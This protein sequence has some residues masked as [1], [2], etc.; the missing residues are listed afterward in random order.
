MNLFLLGAR[1]GFDGMMKEKVLE[2]QMNLICYF[3]VNVTHKLTRIGLNLS[4]T[5]FVCSKF[6]GFNLK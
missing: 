4:T 2:F 5:V 3:A 6:K 1:Y